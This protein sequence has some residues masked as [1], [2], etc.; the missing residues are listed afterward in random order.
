MYDRLDHRIDDVPCHRID[1]V[2]CLES[3]TLK[4]QSSSSIRE[5][6][7]MKMAGISDYL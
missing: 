7:M 1:D 2:P 5:I 3:I 6:E 4:S